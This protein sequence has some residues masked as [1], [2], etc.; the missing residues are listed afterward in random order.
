MTR[1]ETMSDR[2]DSTAGAEAASGRASGTA[3]AA[4]GQHHPATAHGRP[5][6]VDESL[7]ATRSELMTLHAAARARRNAAPLGS[8]A[9]R[10]AVDEIARIEVRIAAVDRAADPP[11]V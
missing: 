6:K 3:D 10:S 2:V 5:T 7:P 4:A 1:D 9:F 8:D 11:L